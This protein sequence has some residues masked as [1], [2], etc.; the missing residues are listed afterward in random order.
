M[1]SGSKLTG[2][3]ERIIGKQSNN[4]YI[5]S[6]MYYDNRGRTVQQSRKNPMGEAEF[7]SIVQEIEEHGVIT[8]RF[9]ETL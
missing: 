8:V 5:W 3:M 9:D 4:P 7:Y 6:V 2:T 1:A